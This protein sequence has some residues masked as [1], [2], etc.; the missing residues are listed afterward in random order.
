MSLPV[1]PVGPLDAEIILVGEAPGADE[2]LK[3]QP[4]V[5][6]SGDILN[7]CLAAVGIPRSSC[8]ITNVSKQKLPKNDGAAYRQ[9]PEFK[10]DTLSLIDELTRLP[11]ARVIVALGGTAWQALSGEFALEGW[12]G[13]PYTPAPPLSQLVL[14]T[15]HP[16]SAIPSRSPLNKHVIKWD[17]GKAVRLMDKGIP[18]PYNI[19]EL[20]PGDAS[21]I[22]DGWPDGEPM[23]FD[24]ETSMLKVK[25]GFAVREMVAVS[26]ANAGAAYVVLLG[27]EGTN[28]WSDDSELRF[29]ESLKRVLENS[30]IPKVGQNLAFDASVLY[31][32]YG[33]ETNNIEDT[34][35]AQAVF[36]PDYEKDL[37][38]LTSVWTDQPYHKHLAKRGEAKVR[39]KF[40]EYAAL[41]AAVVLDILDRQMP[42][43]TAQ[44]NYETYR[45][46]CNMIMPLVKMQDHGLFVDLPSLRQLSKEAKE[47]VT[48]HQAVLNVLA[49]SVYG[50][51]STLNVK[52]PKQKKEF[53]YSKR[54]QGLTPITHKKVVST[55]KKALKKLKAKG[56]KGADEILAITQLRDDDAKYFSILVDPDSRLRGSFSPVTDSGRLSCRRSIFGTGA[57]CQNIPKRMKEHIYADPGCVFVELDLSQVENR[58]VAAYAHESRMLEAFANGVDVH[59]LTAGLIFGKPPEDISRVPGSSALGDGKHSERDW[60]KRANHAL[61][62]GMG[63]LLLASEYEIPAKD[64]KFLYDAYHKAYPNIEGIFWREC[65]DALYKGRTLENAFGRKRMFLGMLNDETFK[66]AYSFKPQSTAADLLNRRGLLS[67]ANHMGAPKIVN[68]VHD[69]LLFMVPIR[70]RVEFMQACV[71]INALALDLQQPITVNGH[72][73]SIPVDTKIGTCYGKL[74]DC[75]TT[76]E[77]IFMAIENRIWET[78]K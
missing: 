48:K 64:G 77:G 17:L 67:P 57:N 15:Y 19:M 66:I 4:F 39:S 53:F 27:W 41:D 25:G 12:R 37:G 63:P 9:S 6:P 75:P 68:Q 74:V 26:F 49:S 58:L 28:C 5:G 23:G 29:M 62:Y 32:R 56:A 7:D 70:N 35:I 8:Y 72:S 78:H 51:P 31:H 18:D 73:M 20:T 2:I 46:H 13:H 65:K 61:N 50:E 40:L 11:K 47:A 38:F 59:S 24:I 22:L 1:P 42:D 30:A 76:A 52:S 14:P 45:H 34:M 21:C 54:G 60:G 44:G 43:L 16:A 10:S 69:A 3:G 33:I 36:M 71:W 55:D